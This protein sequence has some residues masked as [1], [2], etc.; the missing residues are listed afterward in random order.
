VGWNSANRIFDPVARALIK[1]GADDDTKRTTLRDLIKELQEGD[2]DTEDESLE[3]YLHDPVI[4]GAFA[5][6]NVHLS[7]RRCCRAEHADDPRRSLLLMRS[8]DV[9]EDEMSQGLDA[10]AHQLAE[11]IRTDADLR[12][13]EGERSLALY[14]RELADLI[15][16]AARKS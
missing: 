2:W 14:G 15:D 4:V 7:D 16:P 9:D 6:C 3:E 8:E 11:K 12:G 5:D 10:F 13:T 1:A